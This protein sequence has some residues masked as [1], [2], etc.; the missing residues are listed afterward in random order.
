MTSRHMAV[1]VTEAGGRVLL[2]AAATRHVTSMGEC[3]HR[4]GDTYN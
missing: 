1:V 2:E 4:G 3:A